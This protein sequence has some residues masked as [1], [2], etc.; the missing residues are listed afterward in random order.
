MIMR[1]EYFQGKPPKAS[2]KGTGLLG[3]WYWRL[4]AGNGRVIAD[5]AEGYSK[6]SNVIRACEKMQD[7][8]LPRYN[9]KTG[10]ME[11]VPVIEV[12]Q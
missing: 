4:V 7:L 8:L 6:R 2:G 11:K 1:I 12:K 3:Q 9:K 5:G 10:C